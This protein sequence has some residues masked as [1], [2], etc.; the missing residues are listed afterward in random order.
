MKANKSIIEVSDLD[1]GQLNENK[2]IQLKNK[3]YLFNHIILSVGKKFDD[4]SVIK[5]YS[6]PNSHRA[7]VGFFEH[8][9]NHNQ[10]AYEIFTERGPLAVLPSQI[11]KKIPLL[12]FTLQKISYLMALFT[13]L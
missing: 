3:K 6:L 10:T 13:S 5:K 8:S 1:I 9:T 4:N 12:S 11:A 2:I 7:Y